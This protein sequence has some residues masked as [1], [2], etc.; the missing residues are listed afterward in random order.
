MNKAITD[1]LVL[2][3][4]PFSA[5]LNLWS[6]EDGLPG[7][8][9]YAGQ[10]NAAFVAADQD[11]GGCLEI[12][13]AVSV[14][15][16]RCFQQ[17][18][19]QPGMYLRVTARVKAISGAL[20]TVRVAGFAALSNG[21]NA[22][23]LVQT[24]PAVALTAY[25][26]VTTVTAIIGSGNRGGVNMVWGITPTYCH[27]GL[28]ILGPNG[29]ILRIDDIT[30]EDVT[31]VFHRTMMDWVDIRDYGARGDGTTDDTAA[32]LAADADAVASGRMLVVSDG[33][34]LVTSHLTLNA[35]VRFEGTLVMAD[36][37]RLVCT[38]NYDLDTY[39]D[40]F[41][42]EASGFRK[43]L[44]ALFYFSDHSVLDLKGRR[45]D[46]TQP[47][48][49]AA[50]AGLTTF[51]SRR[52]VTNGTL[53][54]VSGSAWETLS[55]SSVATYATAQPTRLTAVANVANIPVGARVSGAGV[56][57]EVYVTA[58]NIAAGTVDISQPLYG[59]AGT[60]TFTFD[61]YRYLLDFSG[62]DNLA[63]FEME[64]IEFGC[65]GLAS[66]VMLAQGGL[67]FQIENCVF[68]RP[69]DRGIT[70]T[71]SGCSG[72]FVDRCQFWSNE[73]PVPSQSRTTVALNVNSNDTKIRDNRVVR[74]A[75]FAVMA[76]T[77]HMFIG[78]HFFQGDDQEVGIRRAGIVFTA[79][80][81][82]SLVTG[83][84]I[85]NCFIE[86]SNEHDATP[87]FESGFS[88]SGLTVG[89]NIF[90][91]TGVGASFRWLVITPRGAGHFLNGLT[92]ANNAF[93]VVGPA[94][95]RVDGI[96]TTFATL[97]FG[98]F[99]NVTVEGN[100]YHGV[101][102]PTVN[103]LVMEHN[104]GTAA[105]TWVVDTAG[106]MPFGGWARNVT[107]VVAKNAITNASNVAQYAQ[108]WSQV[109]Q[110]PSRTFVN[111]RWPAAVRGR[112]NATIRCDNPI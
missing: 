69:R 86:W 25:G 31:E 102:Q 35:R 37:L 6:R 78:N 73:Q 56:G 42:S 18:P 77:G 59:A 49:V 14:Q 53:N 99:R 4:P 72:M 34:Y 98:R 100:T 9:S 96:D 111:L 32:F 67:I 13:K 12:Q 28:D 3:P 36:A 47:V 60:R 51:T 40:A 21:T 75:H 71:G 110:G 84:Y 44:Q 65:N 88:F 38:R 57:R 5:G 76:G 39:S 15:K 19:Y 46:L 16:L 109:E 20:P 43:A 68:N 79:T 54:A 93:R 103:P 33:T 92:I 74:F 41:G 97:D 104:Q 48:D 63:R 90:M 10:P 11:F 22:V 82:R 26:T 8:G 105:D 50:L 27:L 17:I 70:S 95:E 30:V 58:R 55:V 112:V 85:D 64:G 107:S 89:N 2:M 83:N 45:V 81:A 62:F 106:F 24:G 101:T 7:Q 91:A 1:G 29:G 108:P 23:G 52:L 61:R 80:H 87:A 94:I 66:G